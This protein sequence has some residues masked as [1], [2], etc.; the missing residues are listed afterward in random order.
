MKIWAIVATN[1][2]RTARDRMGL[3]FIV[4][5]PL[6]IIMA[7]GLT[8]SGGGATRVGIVDADGSAAAV[9]LWAAIEAGAEAPIETRTYATLDELRD[10]AARGNVEFGLAIPAGY[11]AALQAGATATVTYVSVETG[12]A[13]AARSAVDR[14]VADQAALYRAARFGAAEGLPFEAALEAATSVA[15]RTAGVAVEITSVATATSTSGFLLGAQSQVVLFM[16]LTSLTAATELITTRQLGVAR[17]MFATPTGAG[18]IIVGEGLARF[19]V[20]L[21]Q[22][23]FIIGAT[24]LLFGVAWPDPVATLLIV[25]VFALTCGGAALLIG[26]IAN[27]ASQAGAIG[28]GLGL[29]LGLLG[30]AMV[31]TEVFPEIMQTVSHAT[32][33]AWALDAFRTVLIEGGGLAGVVAP[34]LVLLGYAVVL[35]GLAVI[36]FRRLLL[37]G[38]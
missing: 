11:G 7:L 17:R 37:A 25:T 4:L 3:F 30:G 5:L 18:T 34:V 21:L 14:A 38:G 8:Y 9:D 31:P 10:A 1:M 35:L 32:P 19:L 27:N 20:A 33:H 26:T 13:N 2:R 24:A 22:G 15:E 28:A 23:V 12:R 6:I 36:R 16:F 29:F